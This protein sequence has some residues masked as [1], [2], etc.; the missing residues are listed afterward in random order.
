MKTEAFRHSPSWI[1]VS[2]GVA[3][4]LGALLHES[5]LWRAQWHHRRA[6][7][8]VSRHLPAAA[9][10]ELRLARQ[11]A[12][13]D[14]DLQLSSARLQYQTQHL[15]RALT[16]LTAMQQMGATID[17]V[18]LKARVLMGLGEYRKA[19]TLLE[20]VATAYPNHVTPRFDLGRCYMAL[21][22]PQAALTAF[23]AALKRKAVSPKAQWEQS[24]A[25]NYIDAI[26]RRTENKDDSMQP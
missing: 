7:Q 19:V 25:R 5:S 3:A 22:K 17:A 15:R 14:Y 9:E 13:N 8:M 2:L 20:S 12:P 18:K 1:T 11:L 26:L 23:R 21:N 24:L 16:T 4:L 6:L 10:S